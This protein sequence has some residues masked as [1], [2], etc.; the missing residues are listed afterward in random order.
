MLCLRKWLWYLWIVAWKQGEVQELCQ[1]FGCCDR[2]FPMGWSPG[3]SLL[4]KHGDDVQV[5]STQEA[6]TDTLREMMLKKAYA[7]T[8]IHI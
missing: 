6:L 4:S 7:P 3:P 2:G 5:S 1:E 8:Q